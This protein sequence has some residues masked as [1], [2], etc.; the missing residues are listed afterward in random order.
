MDF[1]NMKKLQ[2]KGQ[3]KSAECNFDISFQIKPTYIYIDKIMLFLII[4]IV[5]NYMVLQQLIKESFSMQGLNK[6]LIFSK[7][8][9]LGNLMTEIC[10]MNYNFNFSMNVYYKYTEY[11]MVVFFIQSI[12]IMIKF[13]ILFECLEQEIQVTTQD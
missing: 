5:L 13:K 7:Y 10:I 9:W 4:Y 11:F 6:L 3:I 12:L 2:I 8:F 1:S